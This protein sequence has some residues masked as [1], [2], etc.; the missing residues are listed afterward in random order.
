LKDRRRKEVRIREGVVK[1]EGKRSKRGGIERERKEG[2][3]NVGAK[4]GVMSMEG[5]LRSKEKR[6]AC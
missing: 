3:Q 2:V 5:R 6:R 4:M 1:S